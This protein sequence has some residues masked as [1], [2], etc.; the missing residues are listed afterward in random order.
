M[1]ESGIISRE[2]VSLVIP[3]YNE[4]EVVP[5]LI[6]EI[7]RFRE[8]C[9]EVDQIILVDDGSGD[10][11]AALIRKSTARLRGYRLLS[12]SRNFGHQIAITAGLDLVESDAA[13]ILDADLQDPLYAVQM[14]IE[15]WK[16]GFD[17]VYGVRKER[18]GDSRFKRL[19]AAL[20][21]RFFRWMTDVQ[22]PVDTGDFRLISRRVIDAYSRVHEQ[23]PFV[24]GM[25]S[26]LGFNQ[27][28]IEYSREERVA[29]QT[30]YTFRRMFRLATDSLT[31][32]SEK[33][34]RIAVRIGL[35][36]SM[37]SVL[38]AVTWVIL[39]K[40]V[41]ETAITGWASL[42]LVVTFFGG[43]NLFFIGL[44]GLYLSRVFDEVKGRPR[45]IVKSTWRSG[46]Q[47]PES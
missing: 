42:I 15:R 10:E 13:V 25:I 16:E 18:P 41:L 20:Y 30:K 4:A 21:Y 36:T 9:P 45:Y 3:L 1:T 7:E 32:F 2:T 35:A 22:M 40:Y 44:V 29:G 5:H 24:R 8:S 39:A 19:T 28:G 14:M 11:T 12:F 47:T 46:D 34:L 37:F 38:F 23:K 31:S 33:P 43:L 27:V 26:W 17:V 6:R